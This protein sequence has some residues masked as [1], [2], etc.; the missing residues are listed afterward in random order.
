MNKLNRIDLNLLVQLD[1]LFEE[2]NVT[3][4]AQRLYLSQS[5]V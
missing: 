2:L 4:A 5:A 1:V 3:R